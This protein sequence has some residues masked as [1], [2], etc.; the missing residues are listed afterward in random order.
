MTEVGYKDREDGLNYAPYIKPG[1][2]PFNMFS[3]AFFSRSQHI[4][5]GWENADPDLLYPGMP[6]KYVFMDHGKY[7]ELKGTLTGVQ[8]N[9]MLQG[10]AGTGKQYIVHATL[11]IVVEPYNQ[12]FELPKIKPHGSF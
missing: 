3:R 8:V 4:T 6:C 2:N 9:R 7:I 12:S 1:T 11:G 5:L 10:N